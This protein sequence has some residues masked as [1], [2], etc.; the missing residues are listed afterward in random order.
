M[1]CLFSIKHHLENG[2]SHDTLATLYKPTKGVFF[3]D[4]YV[5]V[6]IMLIQYPAL[7]NNATFGLANLFD[8]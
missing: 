5:T 1:M 3:G 6:P 4:A 8:K 7:K 2:V